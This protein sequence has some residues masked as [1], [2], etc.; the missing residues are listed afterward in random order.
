MSYS[1]ITDF[2]ALVRVTAGE[3]QIARI[4][5]LDY[6]V[7][8]LARAGVITLSTGQSEPIVNQPTTAWLKPAEPSWTAEGTLYLWNTFTSAYEVATP[9]LWTAILTISLSGYD[10]QSAPDAS[11]T[12]ET[13]TSLVAIQRTSPGATTLRLPTVLSRGGKA[14]QIADWS[15]SVVHHDITLTPAVGNTIMKLAS[16]QLLSTADQ[17]AGITLYPATELNAWVVAP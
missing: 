3:A 12:V 4:P 1:P 9:A 6:V 11:N 16:W 10:F 2:M 13:L 7:A 8:A 17:L 14:L 15:D 5:G